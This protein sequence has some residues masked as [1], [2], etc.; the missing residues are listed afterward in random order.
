MIHWGPASFRCMIHVSML[1]I[2]LVLEKKTLLFVSSSYIH[3]CLSYRQNELIKRIRI[4]NRKNKATNGNNALSSVVERFGRSHRKQCRILLP[5]RNAIAEWKIL[6][7]KRPLSEYIYIYS[8]P[9]TDC[10]VLSELFSVARH[11][12]F[13]SPVNSGSGIIQ[14]GQFSCSNFEYLKII[15]N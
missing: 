2:I 3:Y 9:Q 1:V 12:G 8:H 11:A 15:I 14:L 6:I 5:H 7:P 4:I 13:F 10:F